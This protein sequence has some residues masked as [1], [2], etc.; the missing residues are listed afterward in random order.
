VQASTALDMGRIGTRS[1]D[2]SG[3]RIAGSRIA[4]FATDDSRSGPGTVFK[5]DYTLDTPVR[6]PPGK[7]MQ[8]A[9]MARLPWTHF[10]NLSSRSP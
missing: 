3:V 10:P 7:P 9:S 1:D 8:P 2:L 6:H 5:W 4:S